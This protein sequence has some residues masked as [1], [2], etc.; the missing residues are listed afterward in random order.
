MAFISSPR[1]QHRPASSKHRQ[2]HIKDVSRFEERAERIPGHRRGA[3]A[4]GTIA[5]VIRR[6]R[7]GSPWGNPDFVKLWAGKTVSELGSGIG[8]MALP[9]VAVLTLHAGPAQL[10]LLGAFSAAPALLVGLPAGAWIDRVRRRPVLI[11]ADLGRAAILV[12]V[13]LAAALSALQM[14]QVYLVAAAAGVL[15]LFFAIADRSYLPSLVAREDLVAGNS[16]LGMGGSLAEIGGPALGGVL[17]GAIGAANA[18]LCDVASFLISASCLAGIRAREPEPSRGEGRRTGPDAASGGATVRAE[19]G[20]GLRLV[21]GDPVLRA[22]AA[23]VACFELFGTCIGSLYNLFVIRDLG[24]SPAVLGLLVSTGGIGALLGALLAGPL[25]RRLGLGRLVSVALLV[26]L[27]TGLL[28]PFAG[29]SHLLAV[30][31][32]LVSQ[33]LGDIAIAIYLIGS[34]SIGQ[35]TIPEALLGRASAGMQVLT[36]AAGLIGALLAGTLG[37]AIGVRATLLVGV[38]GV[39]A[40]ASWLVLSPLPRLRNG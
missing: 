22:L 35:M 16:A 12:T 20:E 23:S 31:M 25:S 27:P 29:G 14:A 18:V 26:T 39:A 34:A 24:L 2:P 19:I 15:T 11:A 6:H 40:S 8:G 30:A 13:P 3:P 17:V 1:C 5:C 21:L 36:R 9:L 28:I 38:L 10:G 32:L 33:V 7:T 37:T 4:C